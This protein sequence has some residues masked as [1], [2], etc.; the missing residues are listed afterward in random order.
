MGM[1]A[2]HAMQIS[3]FECDNGHYCGLSDCFVIGDVAGQ[4]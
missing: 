1:L 3:A 4:C 2:C